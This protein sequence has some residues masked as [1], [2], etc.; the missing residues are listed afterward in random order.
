MGVQFID[1]KGPILAEIY[2]IKQKYSF[3]Q[4]TFRRDDW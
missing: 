2:S 1:E 3:S 4:W